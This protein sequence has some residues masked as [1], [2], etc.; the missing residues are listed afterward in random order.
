MKHASERGLGLTKADQ[1]THMMEELAQKHQ[2]KLIVL[3]GCSSHSR[4]LLSI[5]LHISTHFNFITVLRHSHRPLI[6]QCTLQIVLQQPKYELLYLL[7][8]FCLSWHILTSCEIA[9][10]RHEHKDILFSGQLHACHLLW[11]TQNTPG[12]GR[13][14]TCSR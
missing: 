4:M 10:V 5:F 9:A 6:E 8:G 14:H 12:T 7:V 13:P 3:A 2:S 1:Q 11:S